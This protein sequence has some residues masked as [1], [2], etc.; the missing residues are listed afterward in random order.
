MRGTD[1]DALSASYAQGRRDERAECEREAGILRDALAESE[2]LRVEAEVELHIIDE[3]LARRPAL[4]DRTNRHDKIAFALSTA[5][6]AEKAEAE[7][8]DLRR[9]LDESERQIAV[10][11]G[12]EREG[13]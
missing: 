5:G 6:R 9:K 11:A 13:E 10:L 7:R 12:K 1:A 8:D 3:V 2:R 4:A